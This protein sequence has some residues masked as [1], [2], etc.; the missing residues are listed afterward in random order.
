MLRA[1]SD[2]YN[3]QRFVDAQSGVYAEARSELQAGQKRSHWMWF[4][5]PQIRGLGSSPTAQKFAISSREEAAAYLAHPV[6]GP[7]L[8]ECVALVNAL[9]GRSISGIFASPDDL[10]FHSC[11]TLF[12]NVTA[13]NAV[14]TAALEKYFSGKLDQATRAI[15]GH[16]S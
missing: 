11:V 8:R 16:A 15:L 14:F 1:A 12:V 10:K 9:E 7:N 3:L 2:P 4:I 6:L 5:F 13:E